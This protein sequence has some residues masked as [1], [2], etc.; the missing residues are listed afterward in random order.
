M[1]KAEIKIRLIEESDIPK[2]AKIYANSFNKANIGENWGTENSEIFINYCYR[3]QP[4]L[5]FIALIQNRIV[6]GIVAFVKP[7][8][9]VKGYD[10]VEMELFVD[11]ESQDQGVATSLMKSL[12]KESIEKYK[13]DRFGGIANSAK[14]FPM[15]WYKTIGLNPTE[16]VY[17]D[18]D[19]KEILAKLEDKEKK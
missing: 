13:I 16:W 17:V 9:R 11:P 7:F 1:G 19:A 8:Q 12:L 4:D 2:V 18:G 5:F 14:D 10:L 3:R 6:G 15:K